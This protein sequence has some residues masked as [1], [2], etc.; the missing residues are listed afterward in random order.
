MAP[1]LAREAPGPAMLPLLEGL[2]PTA[3]ALADALTTPYEDCF[4]IKLADDNAV[5]LAH[6]ADEVGGPLYAVVFRS[7]RKLEADSE[8]LYAADAAA[9]E[10]AKKS[11]GLLKYWYGTLNEQ[12]ECL[13]TCIWSSREHA[14]RALGKPSHIKAMQLASQMYV[15][16]V[17]ERYWIHKCGDSKSGLHLV[18]ERL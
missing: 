12:R 6:Y 18:F 10:E 8:Q 4:L 2:E 11:G 7:I 16:Y 9:H 14:R 17:L 3:G 15:M 5:M 13:A 1:S